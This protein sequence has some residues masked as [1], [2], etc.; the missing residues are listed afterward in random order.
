M[1]LA[2]LD[3]NEILQVLGRNN[4]RPSGPTETTTTQAIADLAGAAPGSPIPASRGG[5]G[6]TTEANALKRMGGSPVWQLVGTRTNAPTGTPFASTQ[7]GA[8]NRSQHFLPFGANRAGR[9]FDLGERDGFRR[10]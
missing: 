9:T 3:G 5:T 8:T 7:P 4:S 2:T 6:A 10:Q 1:A